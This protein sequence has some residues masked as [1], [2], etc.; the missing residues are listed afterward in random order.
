M[1]EDVTVTSIEQDSLITVTCNSVACGSC[2]A[3]GLCNVKNKK[4]TARNDRAFQVKEGD[5][6]RIFLPPGKTILSSFMT[7]IFPIIFF[8]LAYLLA[9]FWI[10][11]E[12]AAIGIGLLGVAFGF[13]IT[14]LFSRSRSR[15]YIPEVIEILDTVQ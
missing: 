8:P 5:R 2:G 12:L 13:L 6:V 11:S 15:H 10:T 7:L 9:K 4:F 3:K 1:Y 14:W